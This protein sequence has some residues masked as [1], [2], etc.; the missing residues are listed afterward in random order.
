M[1]RYTKFTKNKHRENLYLYGIC[2]EIIIYIQDA[3]DKIKTFD[4]P[5]A[6]LEQQEKKLRRDDETI[7]QEKVDYYLLKHVLLMPLHLPD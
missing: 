6:D 3:E 2:E 4:E 7:R 1:R 5:L